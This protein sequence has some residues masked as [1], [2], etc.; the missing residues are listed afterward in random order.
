MRVFRKQFIYS[1]AV[2]FLIGIVA[3]NADAQQK[4]KHA[5]P[6]G[7]AAN[8]GGDAASNSTTPEIDPKLYGAMKWR[9]I[10]PF[11]GGR[12]LS[13][14]GV[15]SQ[16]NTYYMGAVAGGVWKTNDGGITWDP[17]FDKQS[18]SSIGAVAVSESD[19]NVVYAGTG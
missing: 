14:S 17:L 19:P 11:R 15:T 4:R 9:L 7:Q 5:K 12:V 10:G 6:D 13:V 16:P 18:V 1:L 2:P 8:A 3:F